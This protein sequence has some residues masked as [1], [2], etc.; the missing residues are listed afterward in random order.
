[1]VMQVHDELVFDFPKMEAKWPFGKR[2]G[3]PG[4]VGT[5][6][7]IRELMEAGGEDIGVPTPV[8]A[9]YHEE[10]WGTGVSL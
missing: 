3:R 6:M 2:K 9:T 4:N 5:I 10:H 1:M 8:S 7:E